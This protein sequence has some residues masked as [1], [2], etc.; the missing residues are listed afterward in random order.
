MNQGGVVPTLKVQLRL[1]V[2]AVVDDH[3]QPIACA[4]WRNR[5]ERTVAEDVRSFRLG[6]QVHLMP[7]FRPEVGQPE[8]MRGGENGELV[9]ATIAK[10]DSFGQPVTW[11]VAGVGGPKG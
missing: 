11:D 7:E 4:H 3:I 9:A 6:G 10:H 2:D 5:A 1:L 8:M